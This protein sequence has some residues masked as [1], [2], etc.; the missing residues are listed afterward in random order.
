MDPF[1]PLGR[2]LPRQV[3]HVPYRLD[4]GMTDT[5][6]D[7]LRSSGAILVVACSP[8]SVLLYNAKAY[9]LQTKFARDVAQ[10]VSEDPALAE[11]PVILL[12]ITNGTNKRAHEEGVADF[13]ALITCSNYT[14]AALENVVR[15]MF[16]S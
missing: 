4:N 15:V 8:E 14:T 1:E 11:I 7:F 2:S 12:L 16:G 5:H 3:R 6:I 13:P 10:K 9:E